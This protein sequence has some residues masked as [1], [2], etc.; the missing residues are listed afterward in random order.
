MR[1]VPGGLRHGCVFV[2]PVSVSVSV[3]VVLVPLVVVGVAV[4]VAVGMSVGL[5]G[6]ATVA[7][8]VPSL[9]T[10]CIVATQPRD[11]ERVRC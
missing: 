7:V 8:M 11:F 3:T 9:F 6:V 2:P 1:L 5:G 10:F 4:A